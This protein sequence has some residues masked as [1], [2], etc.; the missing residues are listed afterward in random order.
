MRPSPENL[1]A[2]LIMDLPV[3]IPMSA[4]RYGERS[5][6]DQHGVVLT[7]PHV[8]DL[9]LDL[10]GYVEHA[11]LGARSLLEPACGDGVFLMSAL[12]RLLKS[13]EREGRSVKELG[14]A[15]VAYDVDEAGVCRSRAAIAEKLGQYRVRK[16]TAAE[17]AE[18]WVTRA[19]FLLTSEPRRFNAIVGNPPYIRIE[20]L[21]Q[22]LQSEYRSRYVSLYDRADLYVAFIERSLNL[23]KP[24]GV[25]SFVCADRWTLN[26]YGAPLRQII[27]DRFHVKCYIDLHRA[28]PFDTD[29]I[30]YPAIFAITPVETTRV[31]VGSL[32]TA[33]V[34]ECRELA[35]ALASANKGLNGSPLFAYESWFRGDEPWILSSP[36]H[37][38]ALR[39]LESLHRFIEDGG[40]TRVGI[41]VATGN[42]DLYIVRDDVDIEPDRLVPL[43][44][45]DDIRRGKI[46]NAQ[47]FVIN[48]FEDDGHLVDLQHYPRLAKYFAAHAETIK[49]RHIAEKNPSAWFRTIDRVYPK[50]VSVPKLLIPDIAG[51]NEVVLERGHYHPH[52]NLYFVTSSVWNLEL[53]GGLLSSKVALFFIWCYAVKMRGGYLRFQAQYLRRIRLPNPEAISP[54]LARTIKVAFGKR[55]FEQLDVLALKA[56]EIDRLPEFDFVDTRK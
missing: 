51:S 25:L 40:A 5:S 46:R 49:A 18:H 7:K 37:L 28:S 21:P 15:I 24:E 34:E 44:M 48:T 33:S 52:H 20:Q 22:K 10:A 17:M 19:D 6:G 41:G 47:R 50:L 11:D 39:T 56:Y 8:V 55:D 13:A 45:R 14:E 3:H 32:K 16:K 31:Y 9:I 4:Y 30:A 36:V 2:Q 27:N 23:L 29:V 53:L 1:S 42:D 43:V 54:A 12:D 26:K 38:N 35:T